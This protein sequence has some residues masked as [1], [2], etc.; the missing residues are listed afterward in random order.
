MPG[1]GLPV[2]RVDDEDGADGLAVPARK[3]KPV[4]SPTQ[5]GAHDDDLTVAGATLAASGV[6]LEEEDV[7]FHDPADPLVVGRRLSLL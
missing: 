2:V 6:S 3:L 7:D 4:G 1:D 5:D